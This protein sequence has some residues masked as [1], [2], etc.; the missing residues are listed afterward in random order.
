[1]RYDKKVLFQLVDS[2]Y[3]TSTGDYTEQV[4][5]EHTEYASMVDT[6]MQTMQL[7][8]G[9]IKQGSITMHLQNKVPYTFNRIMYEG[10]PYM[11]D[12]VINQRVKQAYVLSQWQ[13]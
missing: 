7:V 10:K 6:D 11:V 12:Q 8:Y 13:T 4:T 1:M 3:D 2:V 5:S 9:G